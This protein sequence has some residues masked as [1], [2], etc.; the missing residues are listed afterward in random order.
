MEGANL[1]RA[2]AGNVLIFQNCTKNLWKVQSVPTYMFIYTLRNRTGNLFLRIALADCSRQQETGDGFFKI[3]Q[4][5]DH[6]WSPGGKGIKWKVK[7]V[8]NE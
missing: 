2:F 4:Y 6:S 1:C 5:E 8:Y 7:P 3:C